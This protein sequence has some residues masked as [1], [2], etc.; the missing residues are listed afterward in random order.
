MIHAAEISLGVLS[1]FLDP[2]C[3]GNSVF[4]HSHKLEIISFLAS[5]YSYDS[6][7]ISAISNPEL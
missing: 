4:R 7:R 1:T 3:Y 6:N 5:N 2:N